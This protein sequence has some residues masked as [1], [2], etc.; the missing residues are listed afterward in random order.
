MIATRGFVGNLAGIASGGDKVKISTDA[1]SAASSILLAPNGTADDKFATPQA[2][3]NLS[4]DGSTLTV[5][6]NID[7]TGNFTQTTVNSSTLEIED[8]SVVIAGGSTSSST[9]QSANTAGV[10]LFIHNSDNA[11]ANLARFVYKGM[12]DSASVYGWRIAKESQNDASAAATSYGVGVMHVVSSSTTAAGLT[13][14]IGIG[15]MIFSS[16]S[17][18]GGLFIQVDE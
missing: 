13:T 15:A 11:N 9:L 12:N 14:D 10:G 17:T 1:A 16:H 18:S 7:V 5:T 6:G 4:W 8:A 3:S 2:D